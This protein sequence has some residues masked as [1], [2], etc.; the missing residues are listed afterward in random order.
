MPIAVKRKPWGIWIPTYGRLHNQKTVELLSE[1]HKKKTSLVVRDTEYS[2]H[3]STW[4]D[5]VLGTVSH[6]RPGVADARQTAVDSATDDVVIMLDDDLF[7]GRRLPDWEFGTNAR[8]KKATA[9][10]VHEAIEWLGSNCSEKY[11]MVC[12]AAK[13]A[14]NSIQERYTIENSRIMRAFAVHKPTLLKHEIRF[15]RFYYWEDFHVALSLLELGYPNLVNVDHVTDGVTNAKGGVSRDIA[16][17]KA[18]I[19]EFQELHPTIRVKYKTMPD[20]DGQGV[21]KTVLVPDMTVY[22]KKAFRSKVR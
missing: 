19:E 4:R 18:C 5:R 2:V 15:D 14:N 20:G 8:T 16:K 12:I 6:T 7:F 17:M 1:E 11:P 9:E 3:E 21:S 22:W 13:G 10:A